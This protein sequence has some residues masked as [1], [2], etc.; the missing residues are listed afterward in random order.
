[1]LLLSYRATSLHLKGKCSGIEYRTLSQI[2]DRLYW[3]VFLFRVELFNLKYITSFM[4]LALLCPSLPMI[5]K[6]STIVMWPVVHWCSNRGE[7]TFKCSLYLSSNVL[8]DS[9]IYLSLHSI[10]S[11]LNQYMTLPFLVM[12]SVSLVIPGD[13][14][15]FV[16]L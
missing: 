3:P 15:S 5:L 7:G 14:S 8:D 1:M 10:L 16:F 2:Y 9:P 13:F 6:V 11:H 12:V 4:N